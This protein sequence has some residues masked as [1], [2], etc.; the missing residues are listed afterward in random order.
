MRYGIPFYDGNKWLCYLNPRQDE[1]VDLTFLKG[2][3]LKGF[4][5]ILESRDRK[6][7]KS[8]LIDSLATIDE[9]QLEGIMQAALALDRA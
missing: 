4:N 7:V 6:M 5:G 2:K 3:E 8:L 9:K 1:K